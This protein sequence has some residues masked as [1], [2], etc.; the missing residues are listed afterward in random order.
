MILIFQFDFVDDKEMGKLY[1]IEQ[2]VKKEEE[3]F[4]EITYE[5][6]GVYRVRLCYQ[7]M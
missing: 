5:L 1:N 2:F 3:K 4:S 6:D 7:Y